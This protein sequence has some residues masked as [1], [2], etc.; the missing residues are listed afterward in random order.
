MAG[1][2]IENSLLRIEGGRNV[3]SPFERVVDDPEIWVLELGG[4]LA[5]ET[6]VRRVSA[7][8]ETHGNE[9]SAIQER[10]ATVILYVQTARGRPGVL[11]VDPPLLSLLARLNVAL[12]HFQWSD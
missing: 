9:L 2:L 6:W 7:A 10:G 5:V 4:D 12:E 11:R 1:L 8:L 3:P